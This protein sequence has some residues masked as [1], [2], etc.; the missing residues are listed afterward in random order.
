MKARIILVFLMFIA[1]VTF[2]Q[3]GMDSGIME[4]IKTKKIAFITEKVGLTP[5]E[6]QKFWP[7]YNQLD[8][9]RTVIMEKRRKLEETF[10][11]KTPGKSESDF[12]KLANEFAALY[13][14]EGKLVEEYNTKLLS[15][16][17]AEKVV[18][19]YFAEG[20]FR[21]YLMHEFRRKPLSF[22]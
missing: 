13:V 9:E 4:L 1:S 7:V 10:N 21:S 14:R 5:Q 3:P 16:L 8:A 17:P 18:K 11:A 22:R 20:Q 15:I 2:A 6:A 19:L 12:R